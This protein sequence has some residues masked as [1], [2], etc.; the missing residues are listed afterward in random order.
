M[1]VGW[2]TLVDFTAGALILRRPV[3][4]AQ[5]AVGALQWVLV[6]TALVG[7]LWLLGLVPPTAVFI[8][9]GLVALF[10]SLG[11]NAVSPAWWW[12]GRINWRR[13]AT[14]S[15]LVFIA[16]NLASALVQDFTSSVK[17]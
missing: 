6:L 12:I 7:A 5:R 3:G 14:L 17:R 15:A 16:G 11:W 8:A 10:N 9:V 13:V 4:C 1:A 2:Y